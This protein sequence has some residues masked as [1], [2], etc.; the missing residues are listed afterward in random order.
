MNR[1]LRP[2]IVAL[3][4]CQQKTFVGNA[5][6]GDLTR[7]GNFYGERLGRSNGGPRPTNI[8]DS[9]HAAN[10]LDPGTWSNQEKLEKLTAHFLKKGLNKGPTS[11]QMSVWNQVAL[12]ADQVKYAAVDAAVSL[13][14]DEAIAKQTAQSQRVQA[15]VF[16][17]GDRVSL[18]ASG[19][20]QCVATGIVVQAR[21]EH[22]QR[23][24]IVSV[25]VRECDVHAPGALMP[26][27]GVS[28][29][30]DCLGGGQTIGGLFEG[31]N[32]SCDTAYVAWR[33]TD[34]RNSSTN[35]EDGDVAGLDGGPPPSP[36]CAPLYPTAPC[37]PHCPMCTPLPHVY[38]SA[39]LY[40]TAPDVPHCPM[41]VERL[42]MGMLRMEALSTDQKAL[43]MER[44]PMRQRLP[45]RRHSGMQVGRTQSN[46]CYL[47]YYMQ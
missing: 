23:P 4:Q 45:G 29:V 14:L 26:D 33:R 44:G 7:L 6:Q 46:K 38:P 24:D 27:L 31:P 43:C 21:P 13:R 30:L 8:R 22:A 34:L 19:N 16:Q 3:L 11:A 25:L 15:G 17:N 1:K 39:P 40:P 28:S 5:V 9:S 20:S 41:K 47:T 37:V 36:L 10:K 32:S 35:S 12:T 2:E 18:L 42:R